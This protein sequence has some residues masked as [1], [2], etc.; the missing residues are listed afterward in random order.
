MKSEGKSHYLSTEDP[1]RSNWLRFIRPAPSREERNVSLVTKNGELF[2]VTTADLSANE[3]LLYWT[4]DTISAWSKKRMSKSSE[5][6]NIL[7]LITVW[8]DQVPFA[9]LACSQALRL[10]T[11]E[12]QAPS[13]LPVAAIKEFKYIPF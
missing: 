10:G 8:L 9:S 1:Q 7:E 4:D 5:E 3:E 11:P 12:M 13:G 2:F 6:K